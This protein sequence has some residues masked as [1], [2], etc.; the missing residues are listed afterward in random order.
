VEVKKNS[1]N[2]KALNQIK[3]YMEKEKI[4]NG[5]LIG[6]TLDVQLPSNIKFLKVD[7]FERELEKDDYQELMKIQ[8][9]NVKSLILEKLS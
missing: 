8:N 4:K 7:V 2:N 9:E 5:L 6:E 1:I 3:K